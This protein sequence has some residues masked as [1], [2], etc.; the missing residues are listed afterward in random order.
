MNPYEIL[1]L[2]KHCSNKEITKALRR[3][4]KIHHPDTG[5]NPEMFNQIMLAVQIL[6][7]PNRRKLFDEHGLCFDVSENLIQQEVIGKLKEMIRE[8]I[9]HEL[10]SGRQFPINNFLLRKVNEQISLINRE[11]ETMNSHIKILNAR[12]SK[13][14]VVEG[15]VNHVHAVIE[16]YIQIIK[17]NIM[18]IEKSRYMINLIKDVAEKYSS[19]DI[20]SMGMSSSNS[21]TV[22]FRW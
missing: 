3:L 16:E 19:E 5:G 13:I 7:D 9:Q 11:I 20:Q 18:N 2:D 4:S 6:R 15:Q 17:N 14:S 21:S 10:Q 8:W 12:K 1:E 22:Y